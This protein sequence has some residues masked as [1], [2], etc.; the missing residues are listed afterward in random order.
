M[1][2]TQKRTRRRD[3]KKRKPSRK[4]QLSDGRLEMRATD[5]SLEQEKIVSSPETRHPWQDRL[6][7]KGEQKQ[8]THASTAKKTFFGV[9]RKHRRI[10]F[11]VTVVRIHF[12]LISI[13]YMSL[14]ALL[15]PTGKIQMV[16]QT[17]NK[18]K[19]L[20]KNTQL[21]IA[22]K[23][24]LKSEFLVHSCA[25]SKLTH[26]HSSQCVSDKDDIEDAEKPKRPCSIL[27]KT[28]NY[29]PPL[30]TRDNSEYTV[31][32]I[33]K[34]LD[35]LARTYLDRLH[36]RYRGGN[37]PESKQYI[38]AL[39]YAAVYSAKAG[40]KCTLDCSM[41][42]EAVAAKITKCRKQKIKNANAAAAKL[43]KTS[44]EENRRCYFKENVE[45]N[46]YTPH[47]FEE[48][49]R[50]RRKFQA[51]LDGKS[52]KDLS[53]TKMQFNYKGPIPTED[54][55]RCLAM[56]EMMHNRI[57]QEKP[58]VPIL[59]AASA[60]FRGS[61]SAT[62]SPALL[63]SVKLSTGVKDRLHRNLRSTLDSSDRLREI[64][65][66]EERKHERVQLG[67]RQAQGE[68]KEEE[69]G[70]ELEV[71]AKKRRLNEKIDGDADQSHVIIDSKTD[72]NK[73]IQT[74]V[75]KAGTKNRKASVSNKAEAAE[76]A[77]ENTR[78]RRTEARVI[79]R[80]PECS[81]APIQE[82]VAQ[83]R[84]ATF[85]DTKPRRSTRGHALVAKTAQG[86][87]S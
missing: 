14:S 44:E 50:A 29:Q 43:P 86:G 76:P 70:E 18:S 9:Q 61:R 17:R 54:L 41:S 62:D 27:K 8:S 12:Q 84:Q 24:F 10:L 3:Y 32:N 37:D 58:S 73:V 26:F 56:A 36:R 55:Q 66:A 53:K 28:N 33:P 35:S 80:S 63:E 85:E 25:Y 57:E 15:M 67:K 2:T 83:P 68:D 79:E 72:H 49:D 71:L 34:D 5:G 39:L 42:N 16:I 65:H 13:T 69:D 87:K 51:F 52:A 45:I 4:D 20:L 11:G 75:K 38:V 40:A 59:S 31:V 48:E 78:P 77:K 21:W 7:T 81:R 6:R 74:P 1:A 22:M 19:Q 82:S 23:L 47:A 60:H 30:D 46:V 64:R